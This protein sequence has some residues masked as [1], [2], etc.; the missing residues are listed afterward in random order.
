M[1][2]KFIDAFIGI[3]GLG[4]TEVVQNADAISPDQITTAGNLII[5]VL[6]AIVTIFG[7]FKRKKS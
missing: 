1:N 6:I 7:I 3:G 5:Q 4:L 2:S